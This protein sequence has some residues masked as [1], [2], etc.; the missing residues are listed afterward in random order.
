MRLEQEATPQPARLAFICM[1]RTQQR[2]GHKPIC[3]QIAKTAGIV[4]IAKIKKPGASHKSKGAS[5]QN[6]DPF[7]F[8]YSLT[9]FFPIPSR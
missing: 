7:D 5:I 8:N 3:Q 4:R 2:R 6:A 9:K 1:S